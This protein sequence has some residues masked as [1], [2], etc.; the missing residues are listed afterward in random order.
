MARTPFR[1]EQRAREKNRTPPFASMRTVGR[2]LWGH[3]LERRDTVV[4][5]GQTRLHGPRQGGDPQ[6]VQ[7]KTAPV[8]AR[9][10]R[11]H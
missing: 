4:Q 11:P 8:R 6:T 10:V 1:D 5:V 2:S 9:D 7:V 3:L